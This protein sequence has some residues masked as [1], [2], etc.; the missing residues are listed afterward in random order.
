MKTRFAVLT[1]LIF[2]LLCLLSSAMA[3]DVVSTQE[4]QSPVVVNVAPPAPAETG[5]SP[6]AL[7]LVIGGGLVSI[8]VT[9]SFGLQT[10]GNRADAAN[11]NPLEVAV[12]EKAYESIPSAVVA[13]LIKPLQESLE[14]S[15]AA[16]K[17]VLG[18]LGE[19]SDGTPKASKDAGAQ[20]AN[21]AAF[22]ERLPKRED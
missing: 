7:L 20:S 15:D 11:R 10:I 5:T 19:V 21:G 22:P 3:Q 8:A 2:A 17:Q 18:L 6:L 13:T 16:L 1:I 4:A 9:L 14:R 12:L